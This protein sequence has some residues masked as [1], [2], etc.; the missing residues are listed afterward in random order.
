MGIKFK[1]FFPFALRRTTFEDGG[2]DRRR[3]ITVV[4]YHDGR[5]DYHGK[6]EARHARLKEKHDVLKEARLEQMEARRDEF[7]KAFAAADTATVV[8]VKTE[9]R[10][11]AA[12]KTPR[13]AATA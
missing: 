4:N 8:E 10:T 6:M 12:K 1:L 9:K 5:S 2:K 7:R 13:A 3:D 11:T